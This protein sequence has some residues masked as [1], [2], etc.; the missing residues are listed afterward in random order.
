[1]KL[2]SG[3]FKPGQSIEVDFERGEFAFRARKAREPA[4]VG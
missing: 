3:E 1:M 4:E 2:L